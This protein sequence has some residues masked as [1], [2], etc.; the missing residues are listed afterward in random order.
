MLRYTPGMT[1]ARLVHVQGTVTLQWPGRMLCIQQAS[2][3]ICIDTDQTGRV[4]PGDP[5][6][7]VGFPSVR[8][9]KA[10]MEDA[11]FRLT[12]GAIARPAAKSI[13]AS[14]V[15][16]ED[17][18]GE[19]V[20][21]EGEL[22]GQDRTT[23]DLTLMLRSQDLLFPAI[24]PQSAGSS[25]LPWK[26][27]SIL[28]L[29][30]IC[31]VQID[32]QSTVMGE[33]LI[34]S[35]N[36]QLLLRSLDDVEL[37]RTPSWWTPAHALESLAV[38]TAFA[39]VALA[40]I[41]ILRRQV[42]QRTHA[43]RKSEERLRHLSQHDALTGLP[44]RSM[45]SDRLAVALQRAERF[46]ETLG[47]LMIDVDQFKNVNDTW[48]HLVGDKLLCELAKRI[49]HSVRL[50]DTVARIGGDEFVVLLPDLHVGDQAAAIASKVVSAVA[51]PFD[52]VPGDTPL[53]VT[54]SV[55]VCTYP[56]AGAEMEQLL[57]N[58]DAAMYSVKARGKNG[59][60]VYKPTEM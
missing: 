42:S 56:E 41:V 53:S 20:T 10:T 23:G 13:T 27:G 50:T 34:R 19:L 29:T 35:K 6:D 60:E 11:S 1:L 32:Q 31:N 40:W 58:V 38:L 15:L 52:I 9:F 46:H 3:G 51:K 28:R 25:P 59:F 18:D 2:D 44:N 24:L 12:S 22:I 14:Q 55:G 37:V 54:I 45:L 33:G 30:G 36:V 26:E 49:S 5:V 47:L 16:K 43:L 8:D 39:F 21:L 57:Q 48:G 4:N 7:V 17:H